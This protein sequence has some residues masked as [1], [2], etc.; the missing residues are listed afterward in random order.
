MLDAVLLNAGVYQVSYEL[1]KHGWEQ[2]LQVNTLS[3]VLLAMLLLPTLKAQKGNLP[4]G[5]MPVMQIVGSTRHT[6]A[7]ITPEQDASQNLLEAFNQKSDFATDRQYKVSKLFVHYATRELAK[8]AGDDVIVTVTCPG[9]CESSLPRGYMKNPVMV[10]WIGILYFLAFRTTEQ[11][12]RT[13][14]SA[15]VQGKKV[16]GKWWKDDEIQQ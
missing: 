3:T 5:D 16:H 7:T 6:V 15:T 13:M 8:L 14:V 4:A 12:A 11:G 2:T 1:S 10:F 9:A